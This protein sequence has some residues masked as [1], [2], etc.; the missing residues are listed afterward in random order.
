M[1]L[2]PLG[3]SVHGILR[4]EYWSD[5][6]FPSLGDPPDPGIKPRLSALQAD[7]FPSELPMLIK[8]EI[9]N[10]NIELCLKFYTSV[11]CRH[12]FSSKLDNISAVLEKA[13]WS[14]TQFSVH[15]VGNELITW[16][17]YKDS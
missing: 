17:K 8:Q 13:T 3:S 4:Q 11:I 14:M 1:D 10:T 16:R 9:S 12:K 15:W 2:S 6:P 5:L 7:S